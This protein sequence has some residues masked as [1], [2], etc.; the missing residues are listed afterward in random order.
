MFETLPATSQEFGAWTWQQIAPY[1]DDLLARSLSAETVDDWLADWSRLAALLDEVNTRYGIAITVNTADEETER[2]YNV[3]L[4]EIV[5]R[6]MAAEQSVKEKLIASGL[7]PAGFA[8]PLRKLRADAALFREENVAVLAEARKQTLEYD[9]VAGART[10][11]WEGQQIP[12]TQLTALLYDPDRG[13]RERAW[14][15]WIGRVIDDGPALGDLWRR[16]IATRATLARNAGLANY[17]DVSLA[18][19][20]S[21]RLYAGR[22]QALRG[23]DRGGGGA[24]GEPALRAAA[25]SARRGDDPPVGYVRVAVCGRCAEAIHDDRGAGGE[26]EQRLPA[27]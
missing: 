26:D 5:P 11:Q 16:M 27:G 14:R 13:V 2:R 24:G 15:T 18:A 20:L 22:C 23:G 6:Q 12:A 10:V 4:D 9:G 19:A 17:R 7:E 1:Y 25:G 3:F 21:L 8:V